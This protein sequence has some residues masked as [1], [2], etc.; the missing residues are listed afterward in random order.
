MF[1]NE[2]GTE[3]PL[4]P[5]WAISHIFLRHFPTFPCELNSNR[6]HG[7]SIASVVCSVAN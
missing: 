6:H 7:K 3:E 1:Q 5:L 4:S 2:G